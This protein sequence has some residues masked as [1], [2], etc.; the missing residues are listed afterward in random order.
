M[1]V[2][3]VLSSTVPVLVYNVTPCGNGPRY[4]ED[5]DICFK[6]I[7]LSII[8][9]TATQDIKNT[10]IYNVLLFQQRIIYIYIYIWG[11]TSKIIWHRHIRTKGLGGNKQYCFCNK[12]PRAIPGGSYGA[13]QLY[14]T[15]LLRALFTTSVCYLDVTMMYINYVNCNVKC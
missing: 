8:H 3:I 7:D 2:Y 14:Y 11:L 12:C 13:M 9:W 10:S 15:W 1:G 6:L 4:N 5:I